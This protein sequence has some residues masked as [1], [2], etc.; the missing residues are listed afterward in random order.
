MTTREPIAFRKTLELPHAQA[1]ER[2]IAALRE[3]GFGVL[4]SVDVRKT[5]KERMNADFRAYTIIGACNPPLS[6][7]AFH[8]NLEA[9]LVL[10]CNVIVYEKDGRAE[11]AIA[12]PIVM[13]GTL[14]DPGLDSVAR[15]AKAKLER[16]IQGLS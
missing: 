8:E 14:N 7:R 5:M 9:G 11:V 3:E 13:M 1:L 4:T 2:V 6:Q 10:P 12:D 15:E 16:V